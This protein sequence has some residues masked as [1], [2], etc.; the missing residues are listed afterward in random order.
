MIDKLKLA[1]D[2]KNWAL[3]IEF[4]RQLTGNSLVQE[5]QEPLKPA[6]KVPAPARKNSFDDFTMRPSQPNLGK[7]TSKAEAAEAP[8]KPKSRK[9]KQPVK[10]KDIQFIDTGEGSDEPGFDKINDNVPPTPRKRKPFRPAIMECTI[11]HKKKEVA[12]LFKRDADMYKCDDCLV[13]GATGG[14]E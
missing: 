9:K 13:K 2:T 8:A 11:C 12:P 1:I 10:A 7:K 6:Q 4:Y 3:V 5:A 14:I